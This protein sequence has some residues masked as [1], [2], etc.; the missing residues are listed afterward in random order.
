MFTIGAIGRCLSKA[1]LQAK[2]LNPKCRELVLIAAPKDYRAF[3][4]YPDS[5]NVLIK[6]AADLQRA[7]GLE[8]V[9]VD[10]YRRDGT[11]VTVTGWVALAC[12]MSLVIVSVGGLVMVYRRVIGA[13]RPHT[14]YVKSGDA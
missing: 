5:T 14:Q 1:L 12:I 7:A 4:Q 3:L 11:N 10:P 9:L 8:G 13:D 6:A 2:K